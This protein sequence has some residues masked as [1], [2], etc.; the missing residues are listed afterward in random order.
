MPRRAKDPR[1]KEVENRIGGLVL[2][3]GRKELARRSG[4]DYS[5]LCRRVK[6]IRSLTLG[7]L[8]AIEDAGGQK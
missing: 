6:N 7:E 4:I 2:R 8:W 1:Q 3:L 5:T